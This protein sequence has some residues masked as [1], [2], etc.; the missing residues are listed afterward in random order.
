MKKLISLTLALIMLICVGCD[1]KAN[2]NNHKSGAVAQYVISLNPSVM[3]SDGTVVSARNDA[4]NAMKKDI[5]G[6]NNPE[7]YSATPWQ[8]ITASEDTTWEQRAVRNVSQW[9]DGSGNSNK[10]AP[11]SYKFN[12]SFSNSL[13]VY[14][15]SKMKID[16]ENINKS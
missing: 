7:L 3:Y 16:G 15:T 4:A 6:T 5:N 9:S 10:E 11:Y 1:N 14:D 12:D 13:A 2:V 8:W